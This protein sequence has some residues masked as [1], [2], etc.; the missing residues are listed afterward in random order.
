MR[1]LWHIWEALAATI[2]AIVGW[3]IGGFDGFLAALVA[4]VT[5]D[6]ITGVIAAYTTRE[7]S[8]EVGFKGIARKVVIFTL[9]GVANLLDVHVLGEAGILRTATIFFYLANEGLSI[10]E[11]ATRIGLPVPDKLRDALATI[12]TKS[13][14]KHRLEG[15]FIDRVLDPGPPGDPVPPS[16]GYTDEDHTPP[17][18]RVGGTSIL[19][20]TIN[21]NS[22]KEA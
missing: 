18:P 10:I 16:S 15:G 8:S 7:L 21:T 19:P 17:P 22:D 3:L 9:V 12:T 20:P 14:G 5:I 2:G 13:G 4:F 11:N 6:Y 1:T